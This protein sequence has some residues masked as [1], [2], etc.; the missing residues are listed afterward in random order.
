MTEMMPHKLL[1]QREIDCLTPSADHPVV[2][3]ASARISTHIRSPSF[4]TAV[5]NWAPNRRG[6]CAA[7]WE[8]SCRC[9]AAQLRGDCR[10]L[11][12]SLVDALR[13][14]GCAVPVPIAERVGT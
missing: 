2:S 4:M 1:V 3:N 7:L 8:A 9:C 11:L 12:Q 6:C 14:P 13:E 5:H 10:Q